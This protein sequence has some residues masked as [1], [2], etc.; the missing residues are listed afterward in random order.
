[1][2]FAGT[3]EVPP[4]SWETVC[5]DVKRLILGKLS[6]RELACAG[7]TCKEIRGE[8]RSRLAEEYARLLA[9][10][11]DTYGKEM[12]QGFARAFQQSLRRW[13]Y[14]KSSMPPSQQGLIITAYGNTKLVTDMEAC[15]LRFAEDRLY[16][17]KDH[18]YY[19][20]HAQLWRQLPGDTKIADIDIEARRESEGKTTH[21]NVLINQVAGE[22]AMG[23]LLAICTEMAAGQHHPFTTTT[24]CLTG[25]WGPAGKGEAEELVGPLR[26][27][28]E[29]FTYYPCASLLSGSLDVRKVKEA[30]PL[31]HVRLFWH[32]PQ[33]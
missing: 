24:L 14:Y 16:R 13:D 22:A 15:R 20:F 3:L 4:H 9:V 17:I 12:F 18:S 26:L 10:G 21:L 25:V 32:S 19:S 2:C 27:L 31:G 29:S 8:L 23:L 6:L 30:H 7:C 5:L 11:E 33:P 1:M 28:A